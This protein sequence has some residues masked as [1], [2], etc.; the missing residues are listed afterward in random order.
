M[1]I[2]KLEICNLASLSEATIDFTE[3]PL[4]S[5]GIVLISGSTGSGKSTILD[6]ICLA[7][8]GDAPRLTELHGNRTTEDG[9]WKISSPLQLVRRN[10]DKCFCHLTFEANNGRV[11]IA[12][13]SVSFFT[14]GEN[15]GMPKNVTRTLYDVDAS[16]EQELKGRQNLLDGNEFVGLTYDQFRRTTLLAQG[17]F[18]RFLKGD[19]KEKSGI[20]ERLVGVEIFNEYGERIKNRFS[21]AK[22][23]QEEAEIRV[24][25]IEVMTAEQIAELNN[26]LA[27]AKVTS[28]SLEK[29]LAEVTSVINWMKTEKSYK[30]ILNT[31]TERLSRAAALLVQ[32]EIRQQRDTITRWDTLESLRDITSLIYRTANDIK[33]ENDK[34]SRQAVARAALSLTRQKIDDDITRING[35]IAELKLQ[36]DAFSADEQRLIEHHA[37][38]KERLAHHR[39]AFDALRLAL[40][41]SEETGKLIDDKA[42]ELAKKDLI[43]L[44][45]YVKQ[46]RRLADQFD[47]LQKVESYNKAHLELQK[48]KVSF[49]KAREEFETTDELYRR[50]ALSTENSAKT[51]RASLVVGEKCPVCGSVVETLAVDEAFEEAIRPLKAAVDEAQNAKKE[52]ENHYNTLVAAHAHAR[53]Q[54]KGEIP[55]IEQ[56]RNETDRLKKELNTDPDN[57]NDKIRETNELIEQVIK[58][59]K[60]IAAWQ[61]AKAAVQSK[62][63]DF[64]AANELLAE[65]LKTDSDTIDYTAENE[66]V[67]S[68]VEKSRKLYAALDEEE[69]KLEARKNLAEK[70]DTALIATKELPIIETH[71]TIAFEKSEIEASR[72]IAEYESTV[73]RTRELSQKLQAQKE[74]REKA[75]A[76]L[77]D[78]F[79]QYADDPTIGQR[80]DTIAE[81]RRS[82]HRIDEELNV[83][84]GVFENAKTQYERHQDEQPTSSLNIEQAERQQNELK[85]RKAEIDREIGAID[86]LLTN[87]SQA[88]EKFRRALAQAE[89]ARS[90]F[91][92]WKQL[93]DMFGG[94]RFKRFVC[95]EILSHLIS[96]ANHYYQKFQRRYKMEI[97]PGSFEI[98]VYDKELQLTRAFSSLSGGETFM[99]SLALALGLASLNSVTFAC[100][101]LFIDEGFGSLSSDCLDQVM[102]YLDTLRDMENRRVVVISH[103][104]TLRDRIDTQIRVKRHGS[105]S[106]L[107]A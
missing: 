65:Y 7:L 77:P 82:L 53:K 17:D 71:Q 10:S 27:S 41:S 13:W 45:E 19:E 14:K 21:E 52:A 12:K 28:L 76:L 26:K 95:S 100:D 49:E 73:A 35:K 36:I 34:L 62:Q 6:A 81:M 18:S 23:A 87:D 106:V 104:E 30:D 48:Q 83:A 37:I 72:L 79:K 69:K 86:T 33:D 67:G 63:S 11:Y 84:K 29:N 85:E 99:V 98:K 3:S 32:P 43:E 68:L 4:S 74:E 88:R 78:E 39:K 24:Q 38:V 61:Q 91:A 25:G 75:V 22:K 89:E 80:S 102:D 15:K 96:G 47:L 105:K 90:I 60:A 54:I 94:D 107:E 59:G 50:V 93:N 2:L 101:T 57:A 5:A 40:K 64:D 56:L 46:L 44:Q 31:A 66:R 103:I 8:Y 58:S 20:L 42:L 9:G 92:R 16:E 55:D 70:L 1:K 97:N 51:L